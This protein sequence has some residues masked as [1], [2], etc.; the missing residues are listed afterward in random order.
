MKILKMICPIQRKCEI[1]LLAC[2]AP[3]FSVGNRTYSLMPDFEIVLK[4]FSK[5][6]FFSPVV[7]L[8]ACRSKIFVQPPRLNTP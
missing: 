7:K 1:L 5:I 2:V 3:A 8:Y 6:I 4:Y